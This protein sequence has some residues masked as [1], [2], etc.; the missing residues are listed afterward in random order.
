MML[1]YFFFQLKEISVSH[2][3]EAFLIM[4]SRGPQGDFSITGGSAVAEEFL[5][6]CDHENDPAAI[7]FSYVNTRATLKKISGREPAPDKLRK[8]RAKD[9]DELAKYDLGE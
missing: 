8:R 7:L 2:Q 5:D 1:K 6:L 4:L 9:V 3:V